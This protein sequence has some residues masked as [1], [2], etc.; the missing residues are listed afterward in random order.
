MKIVGL[1]GGIGSGKSAVADIFVSLGVPIIDTDKIAHQLTSA[2]GMANSTIGDEFGPE[3]LESAGGM[4]RSKMRALVFNDPSA[5]QKLESILHPLIR[6]AVKAEINALATPTPYAILAIPL[7]FERMTFRKLIWRT[8]T[9]DCA[10]STQIS[11]VATRSSLAK[12]EI[13]RIIEAQAPRQIRLQLADD[14]VHNEAG[15]AQLRAQVE[16][17]NRRYLETA[18]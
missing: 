12:D 6:D 15:F 5:R 7:L 2:G 4:A 10:I 3:M 11:R 17:L 18:T 8:L 9:V 16:A 14:V 1:T 13:E